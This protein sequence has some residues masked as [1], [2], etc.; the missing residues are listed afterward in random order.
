[1]ATRR[2]KRIKRTKKQVHRA[3]GRK[4]NHRRRRH[5]QRQTG[6]MMRGFAKMF[7][8]KINAR[9][10]TLYDGIEVFSPE[11]G[12]FHIGSRSLYAYDASSTPDD[13]V[14]VAKIR[15]YLKAAGIQ[16]D[17]DMIVLNQVDY[18]KFVKAFASNTFVPT[19]ASAAAVDSAGAAE[20]DDSERNF[21]LQL[22]TKGTPVL[23]FKDKQY[24]IKPGNPIIIKPEYQHDVL[25]NLVFLE[26]TAPN[27]LTVTYTLKKTAEAYC[28]MSM[29]KGHVEDASS[30]LIS[31]NFEFK[32]EIPCITQT[33]KTFL[34]TKGQPFKF[35]DQV[36]PIL[37]K[38]NAYADIT[39]P[40]R[41]GNTNLEY[42]LAYYRNANSDDSVDAATKRQILRILERHAPLSSTMATMSLGATQ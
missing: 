21:E 5:T 24:E 37:D 36:I 4:T 3:R 27:K 23:V 17:N 11:A 10:G 34:A 29:F 9:N 28:A 30:S 6:G 16:H 14:Y 42:S 2:V 35:G 13:K 32:F 38:I 12:A 18:D 25:Q 39:T 31:D 33:I 40:D 7:T 15:F 19:A 26:S 22:N 1:M 8:T 41:H 20:A